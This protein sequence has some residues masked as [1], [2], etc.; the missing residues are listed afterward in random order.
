MRL[1]RLLFCLMVGVMVP[2]ALWGSRDRTQWPNLELCS[3][4]QLCVLVLGPFL[5]GTATAA[6][7]LF[8]PVFG[9]LALRPIGTMPQLVAFL[10]LGFSISMNCPPGSEEIGMILKRLGEND[11]SPRLA[12]AAILLLSA[13]DKDTPSGQLRFL[14]FVLVATIPPLVAMS[15][16]SQR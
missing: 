16:L 4:P 3:L 10:L 2:P 8:A 13:F 6:A 5:A 11:S 9:L 15:A 1:L 12:A 7:F 14:F